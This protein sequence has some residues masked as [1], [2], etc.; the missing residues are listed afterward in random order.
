MNDYGPRD[1]EYADP[2]WPVGCWRLLRERV[3]RWFTRP[4]AAMPKIEDLRR[5]MK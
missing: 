5:A 2:E 3:Y 1:P 4:V